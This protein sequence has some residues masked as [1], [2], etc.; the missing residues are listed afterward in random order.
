MASANCDLSEEVKLVSYNLS[1]FNSCFNLNMQQCEK[2]KNNKEE[3]NKDPKTR[4]NERLEFTTDPC[5]NTI[6]RNVH[7]EQFF[8]PEILRSNQPL[9][10]EERSPSGNNTSTMQ[11][12]I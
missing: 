4:S 3:E 1:N 7:N 6:N 10:N 9:L 11:M 5:T 8:L 12:K 2:V